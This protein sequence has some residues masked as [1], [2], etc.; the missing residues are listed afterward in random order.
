MQCPQCHGADVQRTKLAWESQ[1]SSTRSG[2]LLGQE[3]HTHT[4]LSESFAPPLN[5]RS[6][7]GFLNR[8]FG[9]D[10][11]VQYVL[12]RDLHSHKFPMLSYPAYLTDATRWEQEWFCSQCGCRWVPSDSLA[13]ENLT[14][15][16]DKAIETLQKLDQLRQSGGLTEEEY[17]IH[18]RALLNRLD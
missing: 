1:R 17:G 12:R 4:Q 14:A 5:P 6:F 18:K 16:T 7:L 2:G 9:R 8:F 13:Q 3:T 11:L 15:S 10:I